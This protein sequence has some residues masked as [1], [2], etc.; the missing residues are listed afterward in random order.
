MTIRIF[1]SKTIRIYFSKTIRIYSSK[2]CSNLKWVQVFFIFLSS[3]PLFLDA[4]FLYL[5]VLWRKTSRFSLGFHWLSFF[6]F[7]VSRVL[8][9]PI[10]LLFRPNF[11]IPYLFL[12]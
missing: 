3:Q 8:P 11:C 6:Y 7:V 5:V 4:L 1:F 2:T 12:M 10:V 9:Q